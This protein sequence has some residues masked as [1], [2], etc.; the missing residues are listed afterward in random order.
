MFRVEIVSVDENGIPTIAW[1]PDDASFLY[2]VVASPPAGATTTLTMA[3]APVDSYHNPQSGQAVQLLASA[4]ALAPAAGVNP[5]SYVAS[6]TGIVATVADTYVPG[7]LQI[8]L[9]QPATGPIPSAYLDT[10]QTPQLFARIWVS[11]RGLLALRSASHRAGADLPGPLPR[12]VPAARRP[13]DLGGA[14]GYGG[15]G[16]QHPHGD[17]LRP[18]LREPG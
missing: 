6:P 10:T 13:A 2:R 17:Q 3:S 7:S 15:L 12:G 9:D 8:V 4:V 11:R 1:G 14:T 5:A 16:R 18:E